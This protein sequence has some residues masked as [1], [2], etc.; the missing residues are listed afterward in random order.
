MNKVKFDYRRWLMVRAAE[1]QDEREAQ[2]PISL[3]EYRA[4]KA[5]ERWLERLA[6]IQGGKPPPEAA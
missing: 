3:N 4:R 6:A 2:A 1:A 5:R